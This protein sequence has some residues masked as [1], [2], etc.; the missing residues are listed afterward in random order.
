MLQPL[1]MARK[2]RIKDPVSVTVMIST[3]YHEHLK[4]VLLKLSLQEGKVITLSEA[5]RGLLE[6]VYPMNKTK[7]MFDNEEDKNASKRRRTLK[8]QGTSS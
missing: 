3:E 8:N 4:K 6:E 1:A 7:D 5:I 2:L